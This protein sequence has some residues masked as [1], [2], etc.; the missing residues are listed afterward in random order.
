MRF[1]NKLKFDKDGL[2]PAIIQDHQTNEILML[3]YMNEYTLI[4]TF[5]TS[6][7]HFW[8]RSR[9]K[10]W[11]K[12]ENSGHMQNVKEIWV[13]CDADTILIKVTQKGG[14]CHKGYKS[15]FFRRVTKEGKLEIKSKKIFSPEEV[16]KKRKI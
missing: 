2:V 9:K 3:G 10:V 14:A 11:L 6:E 8:S 16:Y 1:I 4:Q 15:C 12:G 5:L 7:V 13:D